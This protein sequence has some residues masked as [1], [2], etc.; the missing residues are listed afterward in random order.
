MKILF[1]ITMMLFPLGLGFFANGAA[2][3]NKFAFILG[4][5]LMIMGL[6]TTCVSRRNAKTIKEV[7][8]K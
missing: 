1:I 3:P 5:I 6:M 7:K 2:T 8:E 4:I